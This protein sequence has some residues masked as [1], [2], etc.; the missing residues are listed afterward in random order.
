MEDN[1]Q[2]SSQNIA[3]KI[4][5]IRGEKVILDFDLAMLYGVSVKALKQAVRRNIKRFPADFMFVLTSEE[6]KNLRSQF[7]SSSWGGQR[8]TPFAFTEQGVG[9]LSG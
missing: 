1:F 3:G 8:Y 9:M 2:V 7:A 4:H 5:F 6:Y